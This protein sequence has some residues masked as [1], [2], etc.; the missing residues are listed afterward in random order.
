LHVAQSLHH[1]HE[2][3][4]RIGL[5]SA[6]I[7][8]GQDISG[9]GEEAAEFVGGIDTMVGFGWRF[10]NLAELDGQGAGRSSRRGK[11]PAIRHCR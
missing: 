2:P 8:R 5:H 4:N 10:N 3:V 7:A 6:W 9:M 11:K 1:D